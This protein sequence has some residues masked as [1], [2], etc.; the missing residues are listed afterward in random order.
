M[1]CC[2]FPVITKTTPANHVPKILQQQHFINTSTNPDGCHMSNFIRQNSVNMAHKPL[3]VEQPLMES[4]SEKDNLP[5]ITNTEHSPDA[6]ITVLGTS[7]LAREFR[8][9]ERFNWQCHGQLKYLL[10]YFTKLK[11]AIHSFSRS[12]GKNIPE[13]MS[14]ENL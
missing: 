2:K 9:M 10:N 5:C 7:F 4:S 14:P 1:V 3:Q 12:S 13:K 6:K 8:A 11:N